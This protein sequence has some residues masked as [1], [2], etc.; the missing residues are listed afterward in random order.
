MQ[1]LISAFQFH[2]FP[3]YLRFNYIHCLLNQY[4]P[5]CLLAYLLTCL[6]TYLLIS[7]TRFR[8]HIR[9]W[10][11]CLATTDAVSLSGL[12]TVTCVL[13]CIER[14]TNSMLSSFVSKE[15]EKRLVSKRRFHYSQP[16]SRRPWQT[17]PNKTIELKNLNTRQQCTQLPAGHRPR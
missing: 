14:L 7:C 17:K 1:S 15:N 6:L 16:N 13:P 2:S 10:C 5:T 12:T 9:I 3:R 4:L 11:S 8:V